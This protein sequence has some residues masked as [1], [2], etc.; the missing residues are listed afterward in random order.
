MK[1]LRYEDEGIR[2]KKVAWIENGFLFSF[3]DEVPKTVIYAWVSK[4]EA[5]LVEQ[6]HNFLKH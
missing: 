6:E 5:E 2:V 4:M 1:K 3:R